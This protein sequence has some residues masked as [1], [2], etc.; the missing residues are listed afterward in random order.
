MARTKGSRNKATA[1]REAREAAAKVDRDV[2]ERQRI[3]QLN[4][5]DAQHRAIAALYGLASTRSAA[6]PAPPAAELPQRDLEAASEERRASC[7]QCALLHAQSRC[8]PSYR[9]SGRR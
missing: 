8:V 7:L 2:R 9:S 1:E 6:Q 3:L 5:L 4:A